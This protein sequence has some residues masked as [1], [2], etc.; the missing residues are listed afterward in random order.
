MA[1]S[2]DAAV[3]VWLVMQRMIGGRGRCNRRRT[4]RVCAPMKLALAALVAIGLLA[5]PIER[6]AACSCAMFG[7]EEAAASADV[8]FA[9][10]VI[11][12]RDVALGD[13]PPGAVAATVPGP[14]AP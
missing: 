11:D 7:P 3:S 6:A 12:A 4:S 8:V 5:L 2:V 1:A 14:V 13:G 10:T 9:G